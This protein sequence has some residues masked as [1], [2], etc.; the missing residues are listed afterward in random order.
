[1]GGALRRPYNRSNFLFYF[2]SSGWT[3]VKLEICSRKK[4][5]N[6]RERERTVE[7]KN[8]EQSDTWLLENL[9]GT[10]G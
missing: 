4:Q 1:M 9:R 2:S 7:E 6:T 3:L 10:K 8:K 5:T